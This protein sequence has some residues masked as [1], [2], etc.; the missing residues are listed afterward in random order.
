MHIPSYGF[1]RVSGVNQ[2]LNENYGR[3]GNRK[4][5]VD[6]VGIMVYEGATS[7]NFVDNFLNGKGGG[8]TARIP[9]QDLLVGCKGA[10]RKNTVRQLTSEIKRRRLGGMIV[11]YASVIGGFQ[12]EKSFDVTES[13]ESRLAFTEAL[14]DLKFSRGDKNKGGEGD[15]DDTNIVTFGRRNGVGNDDDDE[16][17][18]DV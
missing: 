6:A 13:L 3:N 1:P 7:L 14:N 5:N 8:L 15:D 2:A 16:E 10:A 11:W 9:S 18:E 12:Y 4:S 17:D